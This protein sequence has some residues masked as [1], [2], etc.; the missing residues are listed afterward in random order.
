VPMSQLF[1]A[2][3]IHKKFWSVI[4]DFVRVDRWGS[5]V[6]LTKTVLASLLV[7]VPDDFIR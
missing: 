2:V 7:D 5:M 1:P 3:C 6:V 4:N